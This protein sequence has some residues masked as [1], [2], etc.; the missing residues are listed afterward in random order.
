MQDEARKQLE[1]AEV[2]R[3]LEEAERLK[4]QRKQITVTFQ[5]A[6]GKTLQQVNIAPAETVQDLKAK[7][8]VTDGPA[9]PVKFTLSDG[10]EL[11]D[12]EN[13]STL[14]SGATLTVTVVSAKPVADPNAKAEE[15]GLKT[16]HII[17]IV[18]GGVAILGGV[19]AFL[20]FRN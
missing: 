2:R 16:V 13:V 8:T 15:K 19:A 1:E 6:D 11:R 20:Y 9:S 4:Q 7:Y 17:L 14:T 5:S 18:V 12:G 3:Q 10:K